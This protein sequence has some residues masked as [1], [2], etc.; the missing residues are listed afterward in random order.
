M[1]P[2][3]QPE[4]SVLRVGVCEGHQHPC[5]EVT[6]CSRGCRAT[7]FPQYLSLGPQPGAWRRQRESQGARDLA[8]L[9]GT[10]EGR[11]RSF[12]SQTHYVDNIG[13]VLNL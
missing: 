7:V 11:R 13:N 5:V 1:N 2:D 12:C 10:E 6:G 9:V 4:R 3:P 8:S